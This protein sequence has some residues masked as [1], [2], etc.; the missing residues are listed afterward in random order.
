MKSVPVLFKLVLAHNRKRWV[1]MTL[2]VLGIAVSICLVA[3]IIRGYGAAALDSARSA[4]QESR[5]DVVVSPPSQMM[6]P[7]QRGGGGGPGQRPPPPSTDSAARFVDEKWIEGLRQDGSVA[8]VVPLVTGRL[9]LVDPPPPPQMGPFGGASM[10]G[11]DCPEPL[12]ALAAGEWLDAESGDA[13][14]ISAGFGE[15]NKLGV[16]DAFTV[17]GIGGEVRLTVAG[18][19]Q[20]VPGGGRPGPGAMGSPQVGDVY[21]RLSTAEKIN[22]FGGRMNAVVVSLKERDDLD[23]FVAEWEA[24]TAA[25]QP[26][27]SVRSL[28]QKANPMADRMMGMVKMQAQNATALGF[29]AACFIIFATL[30]GGVRERQRELAS[31]RAIA[32]SRPQLVFMILTEAL[33][34]AVAGWGLGLLLARGLLHAGNALAVHL[35]FFQ[36]GAFADFPLGLTAIWVSGAC[37]LVG[38]LAA[39]IPPIWTGCALRPMDILGGPTEMRVRRFPWRMVST[40]LVLIVL[41]P[42]LVLMAN[43]E[44][45]R[46][47]FSKTYKMGFAPPLLSSAAAI[48]GLAL[49]TPLA[50]RLV[51]QVFGPVLAFLLRIDRRFLRQQLTGNLRRTVGTTVS[52]SAGLTLFVTAL[53]WGYSMLVP[54][55]PDESLPRMLVSILPAGVPVPA[56]GEV[57]AVEG[58]TPGECLALAVEQPRLTEAMLAS[59]PFESVDPSQQHLLFMGVDPARAFG[60]KKPVLDFAFLEGDRETAAKKLAT[61]MYCLVPDHFHTQTGLGVGDKFRVAVPNEAGREVEYEIAGVV[62]VPGWNWFTKF[63]EIRRRSGRAL[64]VVFADFGQVRT[65]FKL[66]RISFFWMNVDGRVGYPEM[67][68]RLL[69]V[70]NRHADV[71]VDVP[72][73]GPALINKQYVKITER[74]DLTARLFRRADDVI[75]QLTQF[76]LL[77]LIIA[78]LAVFNTVFASVQARSWQFGI[79]RGVG[80]SRG[81]LFRLVISESLMIFAAAGV[82]SLAAGVLLAWCGI[83][84]CTYFFYFAGRTPPLVLPWSGL[85][86]G[87]GIAFGLCF[88]AGLIPA[89]RMARKE[90]LAFIQ[91]GRTSG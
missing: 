59:K 77:A 22:G 33:L 62:S 27:V 37:A 52:L 16:G 60:G 28:R 24:R 81:Q 32:L 20:G 51:E 23:G 76:P 69:P 68:R 83:H 39:A 89:W 53:V 54:F 11:S 49:V 65:D 58:V 88:V 71:T 79:L 2:G 44:P 35:Q 46:T 3:W 85:S 55:T 64:A 30:S 74:G 40:G 9:R 13:A 48:V 18:V 17:G 15:R 31:L 57:A 50:V 72:G 34:L 70:A 47:L 78:S 7:G 38:S 61:G 29:L 42:V 90:P 19:L 41:N 86:L 12:Q 67:E 8:E 63:S 80:L 5:F 43:A 66:D 4:Q 84:I 21:V 56:I 87:F 36:E 10:V 6:M 14:V 25:A 91:A 26:P 45:F 75:W 73:V 1:R 82:L